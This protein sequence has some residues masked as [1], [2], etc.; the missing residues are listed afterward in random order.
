MVGDPIVLSTGDASWRGD[1]GCPVAQTPW[2]TADNDRAFHPCVSGC[3]LASDPS[4]EMPLDRS[5]REMD[6]HLK[7]KIM[8]MAD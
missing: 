8:R 3:A 1:A 5:G 7:G 6:A 2:S 4:E